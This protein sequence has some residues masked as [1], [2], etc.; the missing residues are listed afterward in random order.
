MDGKAGLSPQVPALNSWGFSPFFQGSGCH[1]CCF[2]CCCY[3]PSPEYL[4]ALQGPDLPQVCLCAPG[5]QANCLACML[6]TAHCACGSDPRCVC[7]VPWLSPLRTPMP[8]C[9]I[10]LHQQ[11]IS[12]KIKSLWISRWYPQSIKPSMQPLRRVESCETTLVTWSCPAGRSRSKS[13]CHWMSS[14]LLA[15]KL[16]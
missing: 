9:S 6:N 7:A 11:G 12:S 8:C 10:G 3:H 15:A 4:W 16:S 5:S 14:M 1:H 13:E 2:C